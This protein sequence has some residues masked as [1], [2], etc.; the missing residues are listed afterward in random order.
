MKSK[1]KI[2]L[3]YILFALLCLAGAEIYLRYS[4]PSYLSFTYGLKG[5]YIS[6]EKSGFLMKPNYQGIFNLGDRQHQLLI[7]E[8]GLRGNTI[9]TV[10]ASDKKLVFLGDSFAL[11]SPVGEQ[12][13]FVSKLDSLLKE[14][15][16]RVLNLGHN[17]SGPVQHFTRYKQIVSNTK[18]EPDIVILSLYAGNDFSDYADDPQLKI[19]VTEDG[20]LKTTKKNE[21][22]G[23]KKLIMSFFPYL[24]QSIYIKYK[25]TLPSK[26][27]CDYLFEDDYYKRTEVIKTFDYIQKMASYF[28]DK[29]IEFLVVHIPVVS[30]IHP[31]SYVEQDYLTSN[32]LNPNLPSEIIQKYMKKFGISFYD[33]APELVEEST[34]TG[35]RLYHDPLL[36]NHFDNDGHSFVAKKIFQYL[37]INNY[38]IK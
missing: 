23:F 33:L 29:K 19:T 30:Q 4:P 6:D 38:L 18:L 15:S 21:R 7:N 32:K 16:C 36:D 28:K 20:F 13:Y 22:Y 8:N 35:K 37:L 14:N 9:K 31:E 12:D 1:A 5:L 3:F 26:L 24:T 34:K 27:Y 25:S 10:E 11:G 2:V 17:H